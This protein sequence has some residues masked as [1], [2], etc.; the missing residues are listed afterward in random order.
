M[1][2]GS[3]GTASMA[4]MRPPMAAGPIE[5]ASSPPK[6]FESIS[7]SAARAVPAIARPAAARQKSILDF[8]CIHVPFRIGKDWIKVRR[9]G[10]PEETGPPQ[11]GAPTAA[12]A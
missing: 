3:W 1:V 2:S 10:P 9:G 8:Q 5:R 12:G 11:E 7:V 6:V 4:A